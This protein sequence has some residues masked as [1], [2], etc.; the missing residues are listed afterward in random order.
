MSQENSDNQNFEK[1]FTEIVNSEDLKDIQ[2]NFE[3][4][5]KMGTKE[6]LLVQQS[7]TDVISNISEIIIGGLAGEHFIFGED[8]IYHNLLGAIYKISEDFNECMAEYY[9][10]EFFDDEDEDDDEN[11]E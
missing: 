2:E 7:L 6:L 10:E 8:N 3:A 4:D 11:D 9:V 5:V 1:M